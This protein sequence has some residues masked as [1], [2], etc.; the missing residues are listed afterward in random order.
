MP[1]SVKQLNRD[2]LET[3]LTQLASPQDDG[4]LDLIVR[5]PTIGPREVL[6][7]GVLDSAKG[8]S[9]TIG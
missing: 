3:G 5:R 7:T 4:V 1:N 6:T 2:E 9:A 8:S